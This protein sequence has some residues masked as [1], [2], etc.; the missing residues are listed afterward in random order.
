M[1]IAIDSVIK[2]IE[3]MFTITKW[4]RNTWGQV[5]IE[6]KIFISRYK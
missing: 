6:R 3:D 2:V 4:Q 1:D 5:N